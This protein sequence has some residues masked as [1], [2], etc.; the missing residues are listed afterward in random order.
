MADE[1]LNLS[2]ITSFC[3]L[4]D[5]QA[6]HLLDPE[7]KNIFLKYIPYSLNIYKDEDNEYRKR[8]ITILD[9][10][11]NAPPYGEGTDCNILRGL[12][13]IRQSCYMDSVIFSLF[14]IQNDF[15]DEKILDAVIVNDIYICD[16]QNRINIQQELRNITEGI[17]NGSV[18]R[19]CNKL[20]ELFA[21]CPHPIEE[22]HRGG[23]RDAMEFLQYLLSFFD[24]NIATKRVITYGTDD[25]SNVIENINEKIRT[26]EFV[27]LQSSILQFTDADNLR[28]M[29][30]DVNHDI[31][32]FLNLYEDSG[33]LGF[34]FFLSEDLKRIFKRRISV[35]TL[36]DAPYIVFGFDRYFIDTYIN[37]SII[38]S[39]TITLESGAR[40][41]L[42]AIVIYTPGHY[43]SYYKCDTDWFYYND[44]SSEMRHVG[45]FKNLL[46]SNPS[47]ITKGT[48][49]FY[50]RLPDEMNITSLQNSVLPL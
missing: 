17:R 49:Y 3:E 8:A 14:A 50:S 4:G 39:Q 31:K 7:I 15:I 43:T 46:E 2:Y 11:A 41:Q 9:I 27:D 34:N 25:V 37:T 19:Y 23:E 38:P 48:L 21:K 20:R 28:K 40:F 47:P 12:M 45:K 22:F 18:E 36:V 32:N 35:T 42:F 44:L 30:Q 13:N 16:L 29:N 10:L 24:V 1:S 6:L 33:D 26:S 5:P